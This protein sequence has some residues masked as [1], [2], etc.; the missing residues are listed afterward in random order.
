M[1]ENAEKA[2]AMVE[3]GKAVAMDK[4]NRLSEKAD[5]IP[6][7]KGNMKRKLIALGGVVIVG[8][9][10]LSWLFG[11]GVE[12]DVED[13]MYENINK[14][15][16]SEGIEVYD[17]SDIKLDKKDGNYYGTANVILK[18]KKTGER[19][20]KIKYEVAVKDDEIVYASPE[21]AGAIISSALMDDDE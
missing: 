20:R 17:I 14:A 6:F 11:G 2:K 1:N 7:F 3:Q 13:F 16:S 5:A 21:I 4:L 8:F 10:C 15:Y 9:L 19:T 18:N 12:S